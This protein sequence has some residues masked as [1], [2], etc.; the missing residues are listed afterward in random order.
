[1]IGNGCSQSNVEP[2]NI[3]IEVNR[4]IALP[5]LFK[6]CKM[7]NY[8]VFKQKDT[9]FLVLVNVPENKNNTITITTYDLNRKCVLSH[10]LIQKE[11]AD[12]QGINGISCFNKDSILLN[13]YPKDNP[14]VADSSLVLFDFKGSPKHIY[15]L[16]EIPLSNHKNRLA[17][18]Q[19]VNIDYYYTGKAPIYKGALI[20]PFQRVL[21]EGNMNIPIVGGIYANK[22]L[23]MDSS[24]TYDKNLLGN[25]AQDYLPP[26]LTIGHKNT[27][28]ASFGNTSDIW[29]YDSNKR[30]FNR[31]TTKFSTLLKTAH[32]IR[33]DD[34]TNP[35]HM[36]AFEPDAGGY[37]YLYFDDKV[38][39]YIRTLYLPQKDYPK[40]KNG[41]P[42][43]GC[44]ILDTNFQ[45]IAQGVPMS[46]LIS[47]NRE[48]FFDSQFLGLDDITIASKIALGK[49]SDLRDSLFLRYAQVKIKEYPYE[50]KPMQEKGILAF[51]QLPQ[52]GIKLNKNKNIVVSYSLENSCTPCVAEFL[53]ELSSYVQM[54]PK[55]NIF[56]ISVSD[57]NEASPL[58]ATKAHIV[59]VESKKIDGYY[60]Q[61]F[62]PKIYL[63]NGQKVVKT[64]QLST[65][66][67][68]DILKEIETFNK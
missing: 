20:L 51:I 30:K 22:F 53:S 37:L 41:L 58:L 34:K 5:L 23:Y 24:F 25:W 66:N 45:L 16:S 63:I 10:H 35:E 4:R 14:R 61:G 32:T 57:K 38:N 43:I 40:Q 36:D 21:S 60:Y 1:M 68:V 17:R 62:N 2:L 19:R 12:R 13:F 11:W 56:I 44:Q 9:T 27:L 64:L 29:V 59:K 67:Q 39:A 52:N 8:D 28:I 31:I 49:E 50:Q 42:L 33:M 3:T 48:I 46:N 26:R 6:D 7:I 47:P 18:G 65:S 15:D 55:N 54:N